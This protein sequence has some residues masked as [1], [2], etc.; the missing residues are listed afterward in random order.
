MEFFAKAHNRCID[1]NTLF[2]R[3]TI[4]ALPEFSPSIDKV[5]SIDSSSRGEIYSIWGQFDISREKIRYGVRFALLNCPHAFAWTIAVHEHLDVMVV[6]CT[7]DKEEVDSEF[8]ESIQQ[9]VT[10][11]ANGLTNKLVLIT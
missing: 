11:L 7:I 4:E 5:I 1:S 6:H 3:L 2:D 9:F 10:D 8:M